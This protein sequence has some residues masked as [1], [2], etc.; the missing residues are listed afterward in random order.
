MSPQQITTLGI[1][2]AIVPP[3]VFWRALIMGLVVGFLLSHLVNLP[4]RRHARG[5]AGKNIRGWRGWL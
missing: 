3:A 1:D 2:L 4:M 5:M